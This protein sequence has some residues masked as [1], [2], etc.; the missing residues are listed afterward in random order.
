MNKQQKRMVVRQL[1]IPVLIIIA[2]LFYRPVKDFLDQ[3]S[4]LGTMSTDGS[5]LVVS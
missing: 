5:E 1:L 4:A 3:G 2:A